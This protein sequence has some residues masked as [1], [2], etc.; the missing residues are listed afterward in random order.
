M[1][2]KKTEGLYGIILQSPQSLCDS[3]TAQLASI[4][5]CAALA[6]NVPLAH[7]L[8]ALRPLPQGEPLR[9]CAKKG[10]SGVGA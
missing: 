7:L 3:L 4:A 8:N 9:P 6:T 1:Q 5:C 10:S 2:S